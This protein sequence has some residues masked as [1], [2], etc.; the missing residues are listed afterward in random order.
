M[1]H[2]LQTNIFPK[3]PNMNH[4]PE[5][6]NATSNRGRRAVLSREQVINIFRLRNASCSATGSKRDGVGATV[7]ARFFGVSS[8]TVRD[9]WVGRTWYRATQHLDPSRADAF[10]RLQKRPGRPKGAK[11][12][13]PR[14]R[15]FL[16]V[17][18]DIVDVD[19]KCRE[20]PFSADL[21]PGTIQHS[22]PYL[23]A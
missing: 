22:G 20:A 18:T 5:C 12:R 19:T 10:E 21:P 7:V 14:T 11:D 9:I 8:K 17:E 4:Q 1:F 15:R 2:K 16:A 23:W 6:H 13:K 3:S